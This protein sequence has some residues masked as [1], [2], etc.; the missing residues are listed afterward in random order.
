MLE[1][2]LTGEFAL[3]CGISGCIAA[4]IYLASASLVHKVWNRKVERDIY[5]MTPDSDLV[6]GL[7]SVVFGSPVLQLF[8]V[9]HEQYGVSFMYTDIKSYGW[10]WWAASV[11]LYLFLWDATFYVTHKI[12]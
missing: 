1:H 3:R 2:I 7:F 6:L 9:A 10:G 8:G 12:L 11:P 4:L 5:A